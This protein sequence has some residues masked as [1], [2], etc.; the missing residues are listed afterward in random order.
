MQIGNYQGKGHAQTCP[1]TLCHELCKNG[2]TDWFAVWVVASGWLK[3]AQ[4]Q[5]YSPGYANV[6]SLEGTLLQPGKYDWTV[7]VRRR[8]GLMSNYF[9]HFLFLGDLW[10]NRRSGIALAMHHMLR[11][12]STYVIIGLRSLKSMAVWHPLTLGQ[13]LLATVKSNGSA[14]TM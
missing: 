6:P 7:R 2:W 11:G 8:C 5:S 12:T 14:Y 9:D 1:T 3:E 10:D 4:V 13:Q